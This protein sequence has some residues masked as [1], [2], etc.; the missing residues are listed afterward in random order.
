[1]ATLKPLDKPR[2]PANLVSL[3]AVCIYNV[4]KF[5]I[6]RGQYRPCVSTRPE[7]VRYN[8]NNVIIMQLSTSFQNIHEWNYTFLVG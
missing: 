4:E 1:M 7:N 3:V 8:I 2:T 6:G 5:S